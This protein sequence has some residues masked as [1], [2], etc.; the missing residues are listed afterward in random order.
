MPSVPTSGP[1]SHRSR[2]P[3]VT[4]SLRRWLT[5]AL[6]LFALLIIDS[7]YLGAVDVV[8]WWT[9][10]SLE[11]GPYIWAFLAHVVL[12]LLITIPIIVFGI[13]HALRSYDRPNRRAVAVGWALLITASILLITGYL[14]TRVEIGGQEWGIRDSG[15]RDI[16]FWI[17]VGAPFIAM[18]LFVL[19]RLVG[20][21]LRWKRGAVIGGASVAISVIAVWIHLAAT[22]SPPIRGI[23]GERMATAVSSIEKFS[24]SLVETTHGGLISA[25]NLLAIE[26]CRECHPDSHSSW[27]SSVHHLSSFN[28]PLYAF[29]VRNTRQKMVERDG[30]VRPAR[31]CAGCH[32]P[33]VL[34]SGAYDEPRWTDP[35]YDAANTELGSAGINCIVCHAIEEASVLGNASYT[36]A[37]PVRYP[38]AHSTSPFLQWMN[39]QLIRAKPSFHAQTF[40]KPVHQ[41]PEFCGSCH[42]VFLPE[43]LNGYKW[44]PGQNHYDTWRL[45]GVSGRGIT[46]WYFPQQIHENCNQCHMELVPSAGMSARDRD[47]SGVNK[48]HHHG[49]HSGNPAIANLLDLPEKEA[50]LESCRKMIADTTRIDLF[51]LRE[52]GRIDGALRGPI[53]PELPI[54]ERGRTYLLETI[55]RTLKLG[56]PLTQGTADSNEVWIELTI[57]S[58]DLL[59][60]AS[61]RIDEQGVVDPEAKFLNV[62]LLDRE[63]N[64][65]EQRNPE[66]IFVS[67]YNNQVPPGAADLTHY[68]FTVPMDC[69]A[70]IEINARLRYRKFD[71]RLMGHA[72]GSAAKELLEDMPILELASDQVVLPVGEPL[73]DLVPSAAPEA[74]V[75]WNDYGIGLMRTARGKGAGQL[76]QAAEAF[77]KVITSGASVG[78]IHLARAMLAE[79]RIDDASEALEIAGSSE[80]PIHPW[81]ID[82]FAAKVERERGALDAAITRLRKVRDSAYPEAIERGYTFGRDERVLIELATVLFE[83]AR[84]E[85]E[86]RRGILLSESRDLCE[87]ALMMNPQ[88]AM[89][90]YA[91]ARS[92]DALGLSEDA[93]DARAQFELLRP[94]DNAADKAI[95]NARRNS[96]I[97]DHASD[98]IAIYDL[99][100]P[101]PDTISMESP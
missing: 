8:E 85:T 13:R 15:A 98:P 88:S 59:I 35:E 60:A 76:R 53:R 56:H 44:L 43:D 41:S 71:S 96:P 47:G 18:W 2:G 37:D 20:S 51:A 84:I 87:D 38:F 28:N 100:A 39:R 42:K 31:F 32:D 16:V 67:L 58:G 5:V 27:E 86:P 70:Q 95:L 73:I 83:Q 52:D 62:W 10:R 69:G 78:W 97:A 91:L 82:W 92:S 80:A 36:I 79:G 30:S 45:S 75:R 93:E 33:V 63:G 68:A 55:V 1:S 46:A 21:R 12:G 50:V 17:H 94:D 19:H 48:V 34:L 66:D 74:W 3:A 11:Q 64:R 24:P 65:I 23:G 14:I 57:T 81:S 7:L 77:E 26:S 4:R 54:L 6:V 72:Y 40:L 90:W 29:S 101:Q 25:E 22:T 49:F 99:R 89:S 61:G 9:G